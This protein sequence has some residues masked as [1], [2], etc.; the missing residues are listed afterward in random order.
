ML[1]VTITL[2]P[3]SGRGS[4][5]LCR[6]EIVNDETGTEEIGNYDLTL[7]K[8]GEPPTRVRFEGVPR[9]EGPIPFVSACLRAVEQ[10]LK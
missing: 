7:V 4:R 3:A 8:P 6:L 9:D 2:H 5:Q 1:E 10:Y